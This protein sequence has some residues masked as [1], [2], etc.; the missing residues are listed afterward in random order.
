MIGKVEADDIVFTLEDDGS[1]ISDDADTQSAI[2]K[3]FERHTQDY[4]PAMGAFGVGWLEG[5]ARRLGG[6][7]TIE[8]KPEPPEGVVL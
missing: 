6:K 3:E 5:M 8:P 4:S 7:A 2:S 1:I